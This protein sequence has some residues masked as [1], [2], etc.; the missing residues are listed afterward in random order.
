MLVFPAMD[1][2][3]GECIRLNQGN[4]NQQTSY[5][6]PEMWLQKFAAKKIEWMHLVDL[7]GAEDPTN[8]QLD[9]IEHLC[10]LTT[11]KIQCGGG[12]RSY[13]DCVDLLSLG[14]S[15][16]IVGSLAAR[17]PQLVAGW[18]QELGQ[19]QVGIAL[20]L[21]WDR[22]NTPHVRVSGWKESSPHSLEEILEGFSEHNGLWILC[23]DISKDGT[24]EGPA[25]DLYRLLLKSYP[26]FR[27]I[28]S[29]GIRSNKDIQ[30]LQKIGCSGAVVGKAIFEGQVSLEEVQKC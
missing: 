24:L 14:I 3:K 18:I 27:W 5:G 22:I 29:G 6:S 17:Q 1:L 21:N 20:D 4:F 15:R 9:L 16:V 28:A 12:I 30:I 7:E 25:V 11:I 8:R 10:S 19:E 13:Q 23:T 2:F 26:N